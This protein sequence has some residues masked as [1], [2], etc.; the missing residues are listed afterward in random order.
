[1]KYSFRRIAIINR[2]EPAMRLIHAV[3]ELNEE[4]GDE[5]FRTIALYTEPDKNALFVREA[6]E[7]YD[8]G[9]ANFVDPKDGER[10]VRYLDYA[11]LEKA[12]IETQ[13]EAAWVGWGF[14]AEHAEFAELCK[15]LGVT[16]IG[17]SG[18]V[19]RRVGD[20][21]A[22]KLLAESVGVP[23]APWS[24]G[25]VETVD[26]ART[27]AHQLSFP[28]MIKAT[29]GGGGRGVRRVK[30]DEELVAAF[31]SA[32]VEALKFFGSSTV[33]IERAIVG[34]RHIEVQVL[35]D[36]F[37]TCWA[38]GVRDCTIQRRNQKVV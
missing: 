36:H 16:F 21:I 17:P 38:V 8:L 32:R 25:A 10:K 4:F 30:N 29:A 15:K 18:D 13:A 23:V 26:A 14:V 20:K 34:A 28:I 6:D 37:G 19:M 2:G 33:F 7:A 22:S 9:T 31:D 3:R 24:Q 11:A 1:M 5:T 27:H 12:L 35:A